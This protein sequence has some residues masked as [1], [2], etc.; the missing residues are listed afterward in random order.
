MVGFLYY[1]R[2]E[3]EK[4]IES[5]IEV[6][7]KVKK[8]D[9]DC[10]FFI[11]GTGSFENKILEL[12]DQRIHFFGR[13]PLSTIQKYLSNIDYCL[14]PSEFLETFWLS[15]LN[16]LSRWIP[17]IWYKKWGM[18]PFIF[19]DC[20]LYTFKGDT[21]AKRLY[22]AITKICSFS[23]EELQEKKE[24]Y[25]YEITLLM[26]QYSKNTRYLNFCQ[27]SEILR[28][29]EKKSK[30]STQE[31]H[32]LKIVLVSDFIN[33][34]WGIET[35]LHEA[36]EYLETLDYTVLLWGNEN[37]PWFLGKLIRYRWIL[38]SPFNFWSK[39]RFKKFLNKEQP[40]I[41]RFHSL[42]RWLGK[43]VVEAAAEYQKREK[44][45]ELWMMYH[46]FW[47]FYPYPH[48]LFEV[49]FCKTPLSMKNFLD[50]QKG[51]KKFFA[52]W[53]YLLMKGLVKVLKESINLHLVPSEY[54]K[55]IVVQS[56]QIADK[57]VKVFPHFIQD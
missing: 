44:K 24:T 1:G 39:I 16:A 4:G 13:K 50:Q 26:D 37:K 48:T 41:I 49:K 20:N 56:Y 19:S 5:L 40:D 27:L 43:G 29:Q 45:S 46:D 34:I 47:Y 14:M 52:R 15:A 30:N 21:T 55:E 22:S 36:K 10:E 57:K 7:H 31:N 25:Q 32:P 42:L 23:K 33:K 28:Q 9:L 3:K 54:M 51:I 2:L 53:K 12:T 6:L 18:E 38:S 8:S 11:F 17:V 35:Y